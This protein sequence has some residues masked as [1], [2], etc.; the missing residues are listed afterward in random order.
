MRTTTLAKPHR[1][2][3]MVGQR[4]SWKNRSDDTHDSLRGIEN[5]MMGN[6]IVN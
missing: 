1:E 5:K 4:Y 2:G 3:I 6:E